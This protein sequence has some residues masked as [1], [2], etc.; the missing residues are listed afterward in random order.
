VKIDWNRWRRRHKTLTIEIRGSEPAGRKPQGRPIVALA[1]VSRV[2]K[3]SWRA[4][5]QTYPWP[6]SYENFNR[7]EDA[8]L[9]AQ[10]R[11]PLLEIASLE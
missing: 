4:T 11:L 3:G 9:W 1:T 10:E 5:L 2:R 8:L 6:R 7:M